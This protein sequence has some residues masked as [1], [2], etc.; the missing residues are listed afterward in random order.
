MHN[1][2]LEAL[3]S[4][5]IFK[6]GKTNQKVHQLADRIHQLETQLQQQKFL[7]IDTHKPP[8]KKSI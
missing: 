1:D 4:D 2:S 7:Y 5:L 3:I 6:I 8:L